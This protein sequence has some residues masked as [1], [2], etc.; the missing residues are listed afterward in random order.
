MQK[1]LERKAVCRSAVLVLGSH[2]GTQDEIRQFLFDLYGDGRR[3]G[4]LAS[5]PL[6]AAAAGG[7]HTSPAN[8]VLTTL[9]NVF[10]PTFVPL[11]VPKRTPAQ[12]SL[13]VLFITR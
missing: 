2:L 11:P 10:P 6:I 3:E 9:K 1:A 5:I 4:R 8:V 12:A 13:M 7:V